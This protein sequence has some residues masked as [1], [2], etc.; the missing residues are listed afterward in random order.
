[1]EHWVG[2]QFKCHDDKPFKWLIFIDCF[3]IKLT[4]TSNVNSMTLQLVTK[5][6]SAN[7]L[8]IFWMDK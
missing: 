6:K 8:S 3:G 2:K 4:K 7:E 5:L 1:M